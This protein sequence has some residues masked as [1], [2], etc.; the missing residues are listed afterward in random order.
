VGGSLQKT[1]KIL[2]NPAGGFMREIL[3][4]R[5]EKLWNE[6]NLIIKGSKNTNNNNR[7]TCGNYFAMSDYEEWKNGVKELLIKAYG[8]DS[9]YCS[10]CDRIEDNIS[11]QYLKMLQYMS[12]FTMVKSDFDKKGK[13]SGDSNI[14]A[15]FDRLEN[16]AQ[17]TE[18]QA[19]IQA[20][21][22]MRDNVGKP[23]F[24]EH[25]KKFNKLILPHIPL[26]AEFLPQLSDML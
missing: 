16:A 8:K 18:K 2:H 25:Y 11:G 5:F 24:M 13:T 12:L 22:E 1:K 6:G 19:I 3:R 15:F 10:A 17:M 23:A 21:N 9:P 20:V 4:K 14:S 7:N 26:F